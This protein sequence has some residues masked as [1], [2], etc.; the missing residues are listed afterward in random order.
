MKTCVLSFF[1]GLFIFNAY[2]AASES[3]ELY[4]LTEVKRMSLTGHKYKEI[5]YEFNN[6]SNAKLKGYVDGFIEGAAKSIFEQ[7]KYG[8]NPLLICFP[9]KKFDMNAKDAYELMETYYNMLSEKGKS[10]VDELKT[11]FV[12]LLAAKT[13]YPC[14]IKAK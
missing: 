5:K 14:E 7:A 13:L 6:M 10:M 4:Y 1:L 12:F 3:S 2:A 9:E 8:G 11:P